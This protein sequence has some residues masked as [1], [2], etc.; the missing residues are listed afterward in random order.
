M[1]PL[2][3]LVSLAAGPD[4]AGWLS[5]ASVAAAITVIG[6]AIITW[7]NSWLQR[8]HEQNLREQDRLHEDAIRQLQLEHER[9]LELDRDARALRDRK[10]E[11]HSGDL[12]VLAAIANDLQRVVRGLYV[13]DPM[14]NQNPAIT[15]LFDRDPDKWWAPER[16]DGTEFLALGADGE[17]L[18]QELRRLANA[19]WQY[20]SERVGK[21]E[22]P[23][24]PELLSQL[25]AVIDRIRSQ[26]EDLEKPIG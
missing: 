4:L 13:P 26:L 12:A 6:S 9:R 21:K 20:G 5:I 23:P 1:V 19:V 11:R 15:T 8:R 16:L 10:F 25:Q 24:D 2:L 22:I 7:V 18:R 14:A 3:P 17:M